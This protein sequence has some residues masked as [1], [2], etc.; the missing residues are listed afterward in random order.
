VRSLPA[1][2]PTSYTRARTPDRGHTLLPQVSGDECARALVAA[3]W[4]V[5]EQTDRICRLER[6]E[7]MLIVPRDPVLDRYWLASLLDIARVMPSEFV[8]VLGRTVS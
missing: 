4:V 1:E 3:G 6:S 5:V 7:E 2:E 8:A